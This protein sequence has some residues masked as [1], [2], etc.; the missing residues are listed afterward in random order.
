MSIV[1]CAANILTFVLGWEAMSVASYFLVM[2]ESDEPETRQAGLWYA[3][4]THFGLLLLLPMFFLMVPVGG[5]SAFTDLAAGAAVLS[6]ATRD[7]VFVL[8]VDRVRLEGR[9][10]AAA[11]LAAARPPC[12]AE[13]R[14]GADVGRD[15]QARHLRP[16]ARDARPARRRAGVV[17]RAAARA[18]VDLRAARRAVRADGARSEAAAR[19][20]LGGEHRHHPDWRR[21][22]PAASRLRL[23]RRWP[24]VAFAGALFHTLNHACFKALLFLGAGNVAAR[25]RTRATWKQMG[26]LVKRM[27][28]TALLFLRWARPRSLRCR[29]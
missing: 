10:R 26:G 13:P 12:R 2:T 28:Q 16:A 22:R 11:R 4:M 18:R 5:G 21:R 24:L 3:G 25:R 19:L 7:T 20:S 1:A 23:E 15:D 8:A 6:P 9:A 14:V 17:G 29:R 27:P